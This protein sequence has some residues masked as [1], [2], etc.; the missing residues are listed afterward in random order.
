MSAKVTHGHYRGGASP[1][2]VSWQNMRTR[3]LN[4]NDPTYPRYGGVGVTVCKRWGRF[5][6]FLAD[7]GERPVGMT[8]DRRNGGRGYSKSNCRWATTQEQARNR[9]TSI[10]IAHSSGTKCVAELAREC[11]AVDA[12]TVYRRL[13]AGWSAVDA[14]SRPA[15]PTLTFAGRTQSLAAWARETGV[16]RATIRER[17]KRGWS[18]S[19]ALQ[20]PVRKT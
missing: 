20:T 5:E 18:I 9:R 15:H 10:V 11:A 12:S 8:L 3:C 19:D 2:Y 6:N 4:P 17:L 13:K 7:M 14:L 16:G 1:T